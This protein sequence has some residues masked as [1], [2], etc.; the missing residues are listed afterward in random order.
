MTQEAN[1]IYRV[2]YELEMPDGRIEPIDILERARHFLFSLNEPPIIPRQGEYVAF[3]SDLL[4]NDAEWLR[5]K[6]VFH[7]VTPGPLGDL[8][9]HW[10]T[11]LLTADESIPE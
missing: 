10:V 8:Q 9:H 5:V 6:N 7:G 4:S 1:F 3:K 11:V 2:N